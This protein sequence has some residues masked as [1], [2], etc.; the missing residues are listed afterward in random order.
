MIGKDTSLQ[1]IATIVSEAL[2]RAGVAATLSGGGAVSIYSD[3]AYQS[4]DLD[5]VTAALL[6]D[7]RPVMASLGFEHSGTSRL[8]Q[9]EHPNIDWYIEFV[10]APL[11]FGNLQVSPQNCATLQLEFGELRIITPTQSVMDRLAA[12]FHWNDP[13][14]REQAV[15]V[16][17]N[18][19]IDWEL[20]Q[21]W[22]EGEGQAEAEFQRFRREVG[23]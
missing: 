22:F 3:N 4:S 1:E 7:I 23:R 16:A 11:A 17:R 18:N 14:S 20:L 5:F 15:L 19:E 13:Q 21:H 8:S 2:A 9:F 10:A 12:A 6:E